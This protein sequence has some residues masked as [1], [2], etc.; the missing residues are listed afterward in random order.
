MDIDTTK[1]ELTITAKLIT[2][3]ARKEFF[4]RLAELLES[5]PTSEV[6]LKL[7]FFSANDLQAAK[8]AIAKKLFRRDPDIEIEFNT[9]IK[10]TILRERP[11]KVTPI[12]RAI[13]ETIN[14]DLDGDLEDDLYE[15]FDLRSE[16]A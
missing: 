9:K 12:E 1:A 8:A 7:E 11:P 13:D 4:D 15:G 14:E 10:D 16:Y 3:A 5:Q 6:K 2:P